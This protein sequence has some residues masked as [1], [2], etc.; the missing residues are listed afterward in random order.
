MKYQKKIFVHN[1]LEARALIKESYSRGSELEYQDTLWLTHNGNK[2]FTLDIG[3][4]EFTMN[5]D[6]E[7]ITVE[8]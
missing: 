4:V 2:L 3:D 5:K 1:E 6:R 7:S 8:L